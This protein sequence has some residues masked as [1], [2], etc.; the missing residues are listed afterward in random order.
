M[1]VKGSN[2]AQASVSRYPQVAEMSPITG[3][4]F[5]ER[6]RNTKFGGEV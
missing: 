4:D 2:F 6:G 1:E 5:L 3:I